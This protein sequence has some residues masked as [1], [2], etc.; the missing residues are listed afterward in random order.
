MALNRK[1]LLV[2]LGLFLSGCT[3]PQV[4]QERHFAIPDF[5]KGAPRIAVPALD[6]HAEN[7]GAG[8]IMAALVE[9]ELRGRGQVEVVSL[10]D[11]ADAV[12]RG[13]VTEFGYQ[14]GLHE[15]PVVGVTADLRR[16]CDERTLWAASH[17][18][19]GEGYFFRESVAQV[20]QRVAQ[21]LVDEL[22]A[23]VPGER[24]TCD[25]AGS[26]PVQEAGREV[27]DI[28]FDYRSA[29]IREEDRPALQDLARGLQEQPHLRL[30]I[31]GHTDDVG[32]AEYNR[33]LSRRRA[34]SVREYLVQSV[35]I[36][37]RRIETVGHGE[38]RPVASNETEE[39]RARNRRI[40]AVMLLPDG[41]AGRLTAAE[42]GD[43]EAAS[44]SGETSPGGQQ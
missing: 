35:G 37:G 4:H 14:H 38:S 18:S 3:G 21:R 10:P 36:E 33:D 28:R 17:A 42:G 44:N 34:N 19:V 25:H 22:E 26:A 24:L 39:G 43:G 1:S 13:V 15:E 41:K 5:P 12:F 31:E 8:A 40:E 16:R 7:P 20:A 2:V 9:T 29:D 32:S 23:R 11:R 27:L 6:S 30:R